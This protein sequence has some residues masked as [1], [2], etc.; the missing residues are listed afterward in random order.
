M[1]QALT[2]VTMIQQQNGT[3]VVLG[4]VTVHTKLCGGN[5]SAPPSGPGKFPLYRGATTEVVFDTEV[6]GKAA[7]VVSAAAAAAYGLLSWLSSSG[8]NERRR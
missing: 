6:G 5:A 1:P 8:A 3:D 4:P 7:G 2:L